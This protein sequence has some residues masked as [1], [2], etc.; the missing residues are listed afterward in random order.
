MLFILANDNEKLREDNLDIKIED[1]G[2]YT[3]KVSFKFE[4]K[5]INNQPTL[6]F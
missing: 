4:T 5:K 1:F 3:G 6:K 2:L